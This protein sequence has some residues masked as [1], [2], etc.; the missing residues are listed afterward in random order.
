[1]T[2]NTTSSLKFW[3]GV[4][5]F[6]LH[7][8]I[9]YFLISGSILSIVLTLTH[10]IIHCISRVS[11]FFLYL[12]HHCCP[13]KSLYTSTSLTNTLMSVS[14]SFASSSHRLMLWLC[15]DSRW[16]PICQQDNLI[17]MMCF[18]LTIYGWKWACG[19]RTHLRMFPGGLWFIKWT[20]H[21]GV[22][23]HSFLNQNF[24]PSPPKYSIVHHTIWESTLS[25]QSNKYAITF[26]DTIHVCFGLESELVHLYQTYFLCTN[27]L[28]IDTFSII[29]QNCFF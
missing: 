26:T 9:G 15:H 10:C 20:L 22:R 21:S 18:A 14:E 23:A 3:E 24:L 4:L 19:G 13:I 12:W 11:V 17:F 25:T 1:M 6:C 2:D 16:K 28:N 27:T 8:W 29:L 5:F 7:I